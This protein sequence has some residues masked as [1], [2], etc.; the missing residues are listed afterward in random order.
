VNRGEKRY[1]AKCTPPPPL[2]GPYADIGGDIA[3]DDLG[4]FSAAAAL[5][6][7]RVRVSVL[8]AFDAPGRLSG[9]F[10]VQATVDAGGA[11]RECD[12]G[13]VPFKGGRR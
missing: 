8:A 7:G 5:D 10:R 13:G 2:E 4:A 12:S 9:T 3:I 1:D 6:E 11:R